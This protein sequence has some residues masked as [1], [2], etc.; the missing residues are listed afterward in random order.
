MAHLIHAVFEVAIN[1][2]PEAIQ[3]SLQDLQQ[4]MDAIE[5]TNDRLYFQTAQLF[6]R[7][8]EPGSEAAIRA[9]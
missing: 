9:R 7:L 6:C 3:S 4:V 8:L 2:N 1:G 5:P